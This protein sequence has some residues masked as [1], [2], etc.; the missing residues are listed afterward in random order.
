MDDLILHSSD[1]SSRQVFDWFISIP[2]MSWHYAIHFLPIILLWCCFS[3]GQLRHTVFSG[4]STTL[5][6]LFLSRA[7]PLPIC[8]LLHLSYASCCRLMHQ[9]LPVSL[10]VRCGKQALTW[11]AVLCLK[12]CKWN[13][14]AS[15]GA[16]QT[17]FSSQH[18][19]K[20]KLTDA[21]KCAQT[22]HTCT[23]RGFCVNIL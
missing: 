9:G 17:C 6:L 15:P 8:P 22:T 11:Q 3:F 4:C 10:T 14:F 12:D 18:L 1:L 21:I 20:H 16:L 7:S 19:H 5:I 13:V 23:L 2:V